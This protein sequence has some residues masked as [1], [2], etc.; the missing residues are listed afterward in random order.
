M[1]WRYFPL[2]ITVPKNTAAT[3]PVST[4]YPMVQGL[5]K[6]VEIQIPAGHHG[7]TGIRLLYENV[8]IYPWGVTENWLTDSGALRTAEWGDEIQAW[9][10]YVQ[11]YNTDLVAHQFRL[12][13]EV[14][15]SV[16]PAPAGYGDYAPLTDF[17]QAIYQDITSLISQDAQTSER[18]LVHDNTAGR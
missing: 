7:N 12:L 17:P 8:Q 15:P 9:A 3:A 18:T 14:W 1:H 6:R 2:N 11:T 10:I 13:A 16:E 4:P 5:L